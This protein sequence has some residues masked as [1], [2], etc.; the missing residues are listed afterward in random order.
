MQSHPMTPSTTVFLPQMGCIRA[1]GAD[2]RSFLQS[3]LTHDAAR[4]TPNCG[5]LSGYCSPK[6]RLLAVFLVLETGPE[7]FDLIL[8]LVMVAATLKRLKLFILRSKLGLQDVSESQRV[9]G[10]VGP[11][12]VAALADSGLILKASR[13]ASASHE[14]AAAMRLPATSERAVVIGSEPQLRQIAAASGQPTATW[15]EWLAED[16][17]TGMP[18]VWPET[19]DS[20]VPQTINLDLAEGLSFKKGC[21][22]GQEIVARVH[23]LGRLKSRL[24]R[25]SVAAAATPGMPIYG[26]DGDGQAVGSI[27][28][29]A[30]IGGAAQLLLSLNLMHTHSPHLH[31]GAVDGP[32]LS[33]P[34]LAHGSGQ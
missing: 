5:Q 30:Q 3:Q 22:P 28:T 26:S 20:F 2:A 31:L 19:L 9:M 27:V 14:A 21:Y 34:T 10:V 33:A 11:A 15:Q 32:A 4:I 16:I 23:Y 17:A 29:A 12:A 18:Q 25:S 1:Y 24:H 8:P 13:Y 7:Q 6:G